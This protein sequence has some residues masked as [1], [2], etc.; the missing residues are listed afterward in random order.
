MSRNYKTG[1]IN[2]GKKKRGKFKKEMTMCLP[3]NQM[4][5]DDLEE[6]FKK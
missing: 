3:Q 1:A 5:E 2:K 6:D 4:G